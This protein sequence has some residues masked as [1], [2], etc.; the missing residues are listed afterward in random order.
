M[1]IKVICECG[2]KFS[3]EVVPVNGHMPVAVKCPSCGTDGTAKANV[4]IRDNLSA[5]PSEAPAAAE[6]SPL[7]LNVHRPAAAPE[8]VAAPSPGGRYHGAVPVAG[9][10]ASGNGNGKAKK[11]LAAVW[12]GVLVL[13]CVAAMLAGFGGKK[14][15]RVR[16]LG[17][18]TSMIIRGDANADADEA[19]SR[20]WNLW[21]QDIVI[22][23]I[24]HTNETEIAEACASFWQDNYKKKVTFIATNDLAFEENQIGIIPV[25]N[26]CVQIVGGLTWPKDHFENLTQHLSEKFSTVAVETRDVDFSGAYVFGVFERGEMKFRAEMEIKGKTLEDMEEVVTVVGKDWA[27]EHGFKP[28]EDGFDEF[29]LGEGDLI[30]Q[31]LGFK[32]WDREEWDRC[33]V[34]TELPNRA[35]LGP[36]VRTTAGKAL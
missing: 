33:L 27:R 20:D 24:K 12:K 1:D 5:I 31:R 15:K 4:V 36:N 26:G 25:H 21:G 18:L 10:N 23:L 3:F 14:G 2:T 7:R 22:L 35:P 28:G 9:L 16:F 6:A 13:L 19:E 8:A 11:V 29:H 30:T 17:K 32:L 34:L